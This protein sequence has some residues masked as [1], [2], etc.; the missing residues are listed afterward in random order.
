MKTSIRILAI[1]MLLMPLAVTSTPPAQ[2]PWHHFDLSGFLKSDSDGS[3]SNY[4][5]GAMEHIRGSWRLVH[6]CRVAVADDYGGTNDVFLTGNF[7]RYY[8]SIWCCSPPESIAAAIVLPDTIL[9]GKAIA[10]ASILYPQ[11][12]TG[13]Y[14]EGGGGFFCEQSDTKQYVQGYMYGYIDSLVLQVP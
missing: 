6:S 14:E 5:V 12:H 1:I 7:G 8:L 4:T 11:E 3:V 9:M 2:P 13:T 10:R